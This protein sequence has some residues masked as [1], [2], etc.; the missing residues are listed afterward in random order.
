MRVILKHDLLRR[1]FEPDCR[2][3]AT[4]GLRP[5]LLS[6][7]D[8]AMPKQEPLKMLACLAGDA[9]GRRPC[10]DQIAH[11][12]MRPVRYPHCR[13]L[14]GAMEFSQ[15]E[16][17]APVGLHPVARLDRNERRRD[18][19][20]VMPEFGE[21]PMQTIAARACLVA[22]IKLAPVAAKLLGEPAD[23]IGAVRDR[24]PV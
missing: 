8:P 19:H 10:T 5:A 22:E 21:L 9:Y 23:V 11:R 15:H 4:I 1:V 13:Q 7:M 14:A 16:G 2:Q 3:P 20:A 18:D 12:L 17:I 6:R 24:A